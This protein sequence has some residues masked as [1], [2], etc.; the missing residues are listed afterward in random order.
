MGKKSTWAAV[1]A[2]ALLLAGIAFALAKLYSKPAGNGDAGVSEAWDVLRAVPSD[3][4]AVLV[5]DGSRAARSIIADSTGLLSPIIGN[6]AVMEY[7]AAVGANRTA[8]AL[9]SGG[10]LVPLILT[11][12]DKA[13]SAKLADYTAAAAKAGLKSTVKYNFLIASRSETF[14]GSSA[15]HL[16]EGSSIVN[17]AVAD[18][19][20][21]VSGPLVALF[22]HS[23]AGKALQQFA[24]AFGA[25]RPAAVC[26]EI[27][28]LHEETLR[29]TLADLLAHFTQ[30][31]PRGEFVIL[32]G[33]KP[34]MKATGAPSAP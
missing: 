6:P 23:H 30:H 14:V 31:E 34:D 3:A 25:E 19:T 24:E 15:R 2:A 1:A 10:D 8:V 22:S 16:E 28:K 5:F 9:Q 32:V 33:G 29:G 20:A 21:K 26:R 12:T 18:L 4:V 17:P 13:D 11:K 7:L 27:S